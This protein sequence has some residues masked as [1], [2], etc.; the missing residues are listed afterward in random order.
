[1]DLANR[2]PDP[3]ND[4]LRIGVFYDGGWFSWVWRWFADE[5]AW[6][7]A[8]AF[9][10][11]HDALRWYVHRRLDRPLSN[12]TLTCADYVLGRPD[13][14]DSDG[15]LPRTAGRQWDK[16]LQLSG[17]TRHDARHINGHQIDADALL[18]DIMREQTTKLDLNV[19]VLITGD[20]DFRP[21]AQDLAVTR[22]VVIPRINQS[23]D[24]RAKSRV[25]TPSQLLAAAD[26]TPSWT[27][28]IADALELDY[29]L[30]YPLIHPLPGP[31]PPPDPDGWRPG[32]INRWRRGEQ[33]GFITDRRGH[34]WFTTVEAL[35]DGIDSLP[36]GHC[37]RFKG[38]TTTE[39]DQKYPRARLVHPYQ[40]SHTGSGC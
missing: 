14:V 23:F 32:T 37:V 17:I 34:S 33:F 10:G 9:R 6:A 12:I 20:A 39:R 30:A 27:S 15:G 1:L 29:P 25:L 28:M 8:P 3:L 38:S 19:V 11:I 13:Q 24:S 22:T 16:I 36:E 2:S 7:S 40:P 26:L 35:P 18:A 5:S 31:F 4:E 21:L